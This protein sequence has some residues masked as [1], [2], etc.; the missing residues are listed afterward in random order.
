MPK[1]KNLET[2]KY[3][4]FRVDT[5]VYKTEVPDSF[6]NRVAYKPK[7]IRELTAAIPGTIVE[8]HTEV[9]QKVEIGQNLLILEAMKMRNKVYSPLTGEIKSIIVKT[10]DIVRKN[11]LLIVFK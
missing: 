6:K 2:P 5:A 4:D 3:D 10:G 8:I 7:D 11:A 9:G 1:D